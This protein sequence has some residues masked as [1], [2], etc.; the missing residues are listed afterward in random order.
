MSSEG[1][2]KNL[3]NQN[4]WHEYRMVSGTPVPLAK[5]IVVYDEYEYNINRTR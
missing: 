2:N 4:L 1:Q 3:F 5:A